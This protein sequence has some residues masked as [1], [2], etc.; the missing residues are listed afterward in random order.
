MTKIKS[1]CPRGGAKQRLITPAFTQE[2]KI[3]EKLIG[4]GRLTTDQIDPDLLGQTF[5]AAVQSAEASGG[6][7]NRKAQS[8]DSCQGAAPMAARSLRARASA[9]RP[10][11]AGGVERVK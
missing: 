1:P 11:K 3:E 9:L 6:F 5:Q 7:T 2:R 8:D 4:A 10:I